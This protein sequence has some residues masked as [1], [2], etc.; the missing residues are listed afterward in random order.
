MI[1]ADFLF[2]RNFSTFLRRLQKELPVEKTSSIFLYLVIMFNIIHYI[3]Y[4]IKI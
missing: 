2:Y 3:L 1:H 4:K